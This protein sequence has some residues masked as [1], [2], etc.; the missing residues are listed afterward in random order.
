[1]ESTRYLLTGAGHGDASVAGDAK[2]GSAWSTQEVMNVIVT[3]LGEH[4]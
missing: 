2:A 4:L 3:F 1:V